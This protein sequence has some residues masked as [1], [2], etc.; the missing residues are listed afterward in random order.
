M[1]HCIDVLDWQP[2][3][4]WHHSIVITDR[5][6]FVVGIRLALHVEG[7]QESNRIA[8]EPSTGVRE[9]SLP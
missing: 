1:Q 8:Q 2:W 5:A 3:E 6:T 7:R 4:V 9:G